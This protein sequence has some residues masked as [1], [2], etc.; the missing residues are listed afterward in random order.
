MHVTN[1]FRKNI[2]FGCKLEDSQIYKDF[3]YEGKHLSSNICK[4]KVEA[5][6]FRKSLYFKSVLRYSIN[7]KYQIL[8]KCTNV[9]YSFQ[10]TFRIKLYG[11]LEYPIVNVNYSIYL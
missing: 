6:A 7:I 4:T 8:R 9:T 10:E 2:F 3:F 1:V 5:P 11:I